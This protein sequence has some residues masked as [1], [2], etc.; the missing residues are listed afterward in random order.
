MTFPDE[1]SDKAERVEKAEKAIWIDYTNWD[2]K[3]AMRAVDPLHIWF[4]VSEHFQEHQWFLIGMDVEEKRMRKFAMS[5][6]HL[7][8]LR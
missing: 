2:G 5:N 1:V 8:K 3:R 6:I 7:W 4:G